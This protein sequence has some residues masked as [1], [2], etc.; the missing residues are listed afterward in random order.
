MKTDK[1]IYQLKLFEQATFPGRQIKI[2]RVPGG[3]LWHEMHTDC[4]WQ[5]NVTNSTVTFIPFD[6]EF[7]THRHAEKPSSSAPA[8]E[9][10][11]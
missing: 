2:T 3:W 9:K 11:E 10:E 7:M 8:N 1:D 6:N 5:E 4:S